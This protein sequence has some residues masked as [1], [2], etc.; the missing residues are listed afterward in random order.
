MN[1]MQIL[2]VIHDGRFFLNDTFGFRRRIYGTTKQS[3]K[4]QYI[5]TGKFCNGY[6]SQVFY[7]VE[8]LKDNE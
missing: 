2:L 1:T 3:V 4:L 8:F 6:N 7:L 5:Y